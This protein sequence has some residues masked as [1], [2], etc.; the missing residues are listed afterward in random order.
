LRV[1]AS[2]SIR[3]PLRSAILAPSESERSVYRT[4]GGLRR[5]IQRC[6][7]WIAVM[8]LSKSVMALTCSLTFGGCDRAYCLCG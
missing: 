4:S 8:A 2:G 6:S 1:C 3:G 7:E 5:L